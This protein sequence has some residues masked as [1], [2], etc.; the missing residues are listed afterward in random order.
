MNQHM[1]VMKVV[2]TR[3][4][5]DSSCQKAKCLYD[6]NTNA[7][8]EAGDFVVVTTDATGQT[9]ILDDPSGTPGELYKCT[10]HGLCDVIKS[11]EFKV[12]Y[13]KNA[14]SVNNKYIKC[15]AANNCLPVA[16]SEGSCTNANIG[17]LI[18]SGNAV[19]ICLDKDVSFKLD[20]VEDEEEHFMNLNV[21]ANVPFTKVAS[22]YGVVEVKE[23]EVHM[24]KETITASTPAKMYKYTDAEYKIYIKGGKDVDICKLNNDIVEFKLDSCSED[25]V[26][27]YSLSRKHTWTSAWFWRIKLNCI[28]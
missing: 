1:V 28:K 15:T 27:Y 7:G 24:L 26:T 3:D 11:D 6:D 23:T 10:A 4:V 19:S 13:Y 18:L 25:G 5:V 12:G 8:C 22:K 14:G 9:G 20:E 16:V 2:C 17:E 21:S